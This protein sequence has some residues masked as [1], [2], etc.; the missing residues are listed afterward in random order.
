MNYRATPPELKKVLLFSAFILFTA[1][2]FA[3]SAYYSIDK[4]QYCPWIDSLNKFDTCTTTDEASLIVVNAGKNM[5]VHTTPSMKSVYYVTKYS[6]D[7][8]TYVQ[9]YEVTSNDDRKYTFT[10]DILASEIRVMVFKSDGKIYGL[11]F[12]IKSYWVG[13]NKSSS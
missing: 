7:P 1:S 5:F 4:R 11:T 12:H 2:A 13:D 10:F 3:Q 6:I 8:D 9:T